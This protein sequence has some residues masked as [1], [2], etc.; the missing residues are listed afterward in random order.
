LDRLDFEFF[1]FPIK[2]K[3]KKVV[4]LVSSG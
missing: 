3:Q 1:Y 4:L 2:F